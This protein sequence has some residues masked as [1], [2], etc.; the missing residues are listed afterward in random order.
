MTA[1]SS[2]RVKPLGR[3][4]RSPCEF[5]QRVICRFFMSVGRLA[6]TTILSST[7]SHHFA[8]P[9]DLDFEIKEYCSSCRLRH[10]MR[11][12]VHSPG[13]E[14]HFQLLDNRAFEFH[15]FV[16]FHEVERLASGQL[17]TASAPRFIDRKK[18]LSTSPE[19]APVVPSSRK[20]ENCEVS[21]GERRRR[22]V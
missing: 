19:K 13:G 7:E 22:S 17:I 2:M 20:G 10:R 16:T 12:E 5:V 14:D 4:R 1:R 3:S 6:L 21:S 11:G 8:S 9:A 15:K 18:L